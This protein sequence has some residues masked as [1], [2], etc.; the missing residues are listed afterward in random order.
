M[1]TYIYLQTGILVIGNTG[2]GK[3]SIIK[4]LSGVDTKISDGSERGT[5]ETS[6]ITSKYNENI[7]FIDSVGLQDQ[8]I[9]WKDSNT[10]KKTLQYLHFAKLDALKIIFC[11]AGDTSTRQGLFAKIARFIHRQE[12]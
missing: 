9:K 8:N 2:T 12:Y 1:Y 6:I 10:L 5:D 7:H 11:I 3:S 4:L